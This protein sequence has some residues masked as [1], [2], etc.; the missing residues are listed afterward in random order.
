MAEDQPEAADR[1]RRPRAAEAAQ[2]VLRRL[3]RAWRRI[4]GRRPSR[5]V[6]RHEPPV[7]LQD[8]G[9][10][11]DPEGVSRGVCD[12]ARDPE[13]GAAHQGHRRDRPARQGERGQGRRSG[14]LRF[15]PE[16]RRY[17][18]AAPDRAARLPD[19]RL[20]RENRLL[21]QNQVRMPLDGVIATS[22]SM[23]KVCR[24]IEKV[25]PTNATALLLGESGTGKELLARALHA[26]SPRASRELRRHQ[27]RGDPG[28]AARKR[29][30]RLREGRLHRRRQADTRQVRARR[31]RH[32]VPRRDRR[33]AA[34]RCRPSCCASCR[35]ASS[36]A[37]ADASASRS[38][39]AWS[40]RRTRTCRRSIETGTFRQDL[41]YR[42]S[43]V[44]VRIPPLRDRPGDAVVIAQTVM[45]RR[46]R[47][48]GRV[49]ARI[50]AG[51]AQGHPGLPVA[52]QHPRAR[53]S[54][55]RRGDHDRGQVHRCRRARARRRGQCAG[56]DWLNLRAAR[57]RAE[58]DA[59]RQALALSHGNLSRAAELLGITRPT[60]YDL[61]EKNSISVTERAAEKAKEELE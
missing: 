20:E 49:A 59:I 52:R 15:L 56:V 28:H 25:A 1:R 12:P 21:A 17:G 45:E 23:M 57:Q 16:A 32:A 40:A 43:E 53:K 41:Y 24:M 35:I 9:L 48:H 51:R 26:L 22:D 39:C 13:A 36:S 8:L 46:A 55:Q 44:T 14:R 42:I 31:R 4:R 34:S 29:A 50:H 30:V 58:A 6:R 10:P 54:R 11:P 19:L 5:R 38:T 37:S 3:R 47:E 18:R 27:L 60:L 7:V 2:V 61:L 33:H